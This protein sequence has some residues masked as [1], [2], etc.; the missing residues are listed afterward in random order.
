MLTEDAESEI[1]RLKSK[2]IE[3]TN[4]INMTSDFNEKEELQM[5]IKRIQN[6]I[7]VLEKLKLKK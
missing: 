6:Q 2:K 7:D 5:E 3:V 1:E 4:K